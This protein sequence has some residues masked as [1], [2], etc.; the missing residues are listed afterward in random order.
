MKIRDFFIRLLG[1]ITKEELNKVLDTKL[2]EYLELKNICLNYK[3]LLINKV[4]INS[5]F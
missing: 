5:K 3:T 4:K 1:G 2:L